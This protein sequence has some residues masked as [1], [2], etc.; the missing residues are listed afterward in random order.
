[1]SQPALL[2]GKLAA[3]AAVALRDGQ[4]VGSVELEISTRPGTT[5]A[6]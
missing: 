2:K 1:M 3:Q 5:L 6:P 4:P